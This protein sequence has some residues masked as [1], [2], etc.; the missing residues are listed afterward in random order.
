MRSLSSPPDKAPRLR[1]PGLRWDPL[2]PGAPHTLPPPA[3]DACLVRAG[4]KVASVLGGTRFEL[5]LSQFIKTS[6]SK[7][8]N[9][10]HCPERLGESQFLFTEQLVIPRGCQVAERC[11]MRSPQSPPS[12]WVVCVFPSP[13]RYLGKST[14]AGG[15][16]LYPVIPIPTGKLS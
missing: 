1:E 3:A 9:S 13:S 8:K 16:R 14:G 2:C 11:S 10:E 15:G 5:R 6:F 7:Q 12:P 4:A